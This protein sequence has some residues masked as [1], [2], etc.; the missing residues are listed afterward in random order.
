ML[1]C[2]EGLGGPGWLGSGESCA[3]VLG[4]EHQARPGCA[5]PVLGAR[6][7]REWGKQCRDAGK[8]GH[9]QTGSRGS[10]AR[11]EIAENAFHEQGNPCCCVGKA[12]PRSGESR[13]RFGI[14]EIR[15]EEWEKLYWSVVK[16]R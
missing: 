12:R 8:G 7:F 16:A 2:W 9:G 10:R 13:A 14:E 4:K 3:G 6:R 11:F 15:L 1:A 5:E